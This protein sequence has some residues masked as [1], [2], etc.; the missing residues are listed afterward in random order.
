MNNELKKIL[1]IQTAFIG[2]VILTLPMVQALKRRFPDAAVDIVVIPAAM[3]LLANNPHI[4]SAVSYD[5]RRSEKGIGGFLRLVKKLKSG[6]YDLA[7]VPHRSLRSALIAFFSNIPERIGFDR[8]AGRIFMTKCVRYDPCEHEVER[9]YALLRPLGIEVQ[10]KELPQLYPSA[11]DGEVL[12]RLCGSVP[13]TSDRPWI[14]LAPGT[15]WHTKQWLPE[16]FGAVAQKLAEKYTVIL[17]GGIED[18]ELCEQIRQSVETG[19]CVN[20]AGKLSLLQSAEAVKRCALLLC[21]D[22]APMHLA[23]AMGTPVVAVF[24]ATVPEFGFGPYGS[25]DTVIE[26]KG[27]PCRPCTIHGGKKCPIKTFVC[28]R[29]I[30][31]ADV[32]RVMEEHLMR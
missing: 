17:I 9:D 24:G 20:L 31:S 15:V 25:H 27:L 1:V 12:D 21:N 30:E 28:M 13:P 26:T 16:R 29:S 2:D 32:V 11:H 18:V 3:D 4:A 14:A 10:E 22:S 8:S 23:V 19:H 5:K 7:V 6:T